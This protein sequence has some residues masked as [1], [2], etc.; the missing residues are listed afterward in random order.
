MNCP[1][2]IALN[3]NGNHRYNP[4]IHHRRTI[5]RREYDYSQ[6][7]AYFM[8]ICTRDRECLFGEIVNETMHMNEYGRIIA[9]EWAALTEVQDAIE[10]GEFVV[11]PNH[12]HG[13][14]IF[15]VDIDDI[16][17]VDHTVGAIHE[18]PLQE[19]RRKMALPK[20]IGRFKMRSAKRI[21]LCRN[22]SG[23]PVWQRNYYEHIIRDQADYT[24]IAEYITDN[25]RR[26]VNDSLHPDNDNMCPPTN[27]RRGNS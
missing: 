7:G 27:P 13:I 14:I 19:Q 22:T 4:D 18:L 9:E 21:N 16:D 25:P 26:W 6:R 23:I 20:V 17:H 2:N 15:T 3:T 1:Y 8:T 12:F 10:I 11:M 24:R 5:R